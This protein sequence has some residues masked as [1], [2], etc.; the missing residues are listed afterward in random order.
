MRVYLL[1]LFISA[2]V[3][4]LL[5]PLVRKLALKIG[6]VTM[7]RERDVHTVPMPRL[8]G[9]A[10]F[11][12][13]AVSFLVASQ[14]PFLKES[15]SANSGA[16]GILLGAGV[17]CFIGVLDDIWELTWYAKLA[18]E[19][20]GAGLMAWFGVQLLSVPLLGLTIG[21]ERL[22]LFS[23]ILVVVAVSN[24]VNF[25]DGLDGLAAGV[26]GIAALAFFIYTYYLVRMYSPGD[27]AS[28][29][30]AVV[31]ALVGA[32]I[33]FLPHN[34]NPA[35]IFMGDSGALM[36]GGVIAGASILVTGQIN[37][38]NLSRANTLVA[39]MPLV[40]P[41]MILLIPLVDMTWA[42]IR[43]VSQGKSPFSADSGHLHHRLLRRGHSHRR[44]VLIIYLW[45]AVFSFS[46]VALII[47]DWRYVIA[48]SVLVILFCV[49]VTLRTFSS[50]EGEINLDLEMKKEPKA[51]I[52]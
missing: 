43:R 21:S 22:T 37:P 35:K 5:T 39:F 47:F 24:A 11:L 14:I 20:L 32:C 33:G 46:A 26:I 13:I 9:L 2:F 29:A 1:T 31:V 50:A 17:M 41:I 3:T 34:F 10:M 42:V 48:I 40:I 27:Y 49:Y 36:L 25:I 8:G 23:T 15:F 6:A 16:W 7:I 18:G 12:G 51:E 45:A 30:S 19:I 44:A 4:Y 52:L 28:T 38:E